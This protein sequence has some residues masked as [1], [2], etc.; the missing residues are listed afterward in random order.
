VLALQEVYARAVSDHRRDVGG[1][2]GMAVEPLTDAFRPGRSTPDDARP[3]VEVD[4]TAL[5][6]P[7]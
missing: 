7:S 5:A 4:L 2:V 1:A 6:V 3:A